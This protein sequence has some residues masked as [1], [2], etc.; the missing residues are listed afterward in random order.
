MRPGWVLL[1]G[2]GGAMGAIVAVTGLWALDLTVDLRGPGAGVRVLLGAVTGVVFW[3]WIAAGAWRRATEPDDPY[4]P[5]PVPR[6]VAFVAANV[7]LALVF[8]AI[9]GGGLWADVTMAR[10]EDRTRVV[11]GR[12]ERAARAARLTVDD[13]RALEREW[14]VYLAT[15][16]DG[17]AG[18]DPIE[19]VLAVEGASVVSVATTDTTGAVLFR[20]DEGPPCVVLDIDADDLISTRQTRR[21]S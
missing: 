5:A 15:G 21:C 20:P 2:L 6:S 10:E 18:T 11:E 13:V 17:D 3:T 8:T 19:A 16:V 1:T 9:I 7:V 12:I 14:Q 4:E